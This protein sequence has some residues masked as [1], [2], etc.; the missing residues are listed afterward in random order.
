MC[1]EAAKLRYATRTRD[2]AVVA[3]E[4]GYVVDI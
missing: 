1:L 4:R 3:L 2:I